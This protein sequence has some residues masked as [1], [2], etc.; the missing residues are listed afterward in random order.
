MR[1]GRPSAF[2]ASNGYKSKASVQFDRR[3][4]MR[5]I[6][7]A[8]VAP[9]K[10]PSFS[11]VRKKLPLQRKTKSARFIDS[12]HFGSSVL[13]EPGYPMQEC[14]LL[15]TLRR[16]GIG[17]AH[18]LDHHIK[19]LMHINPKLDRASAAIKLAAGFLV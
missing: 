16:L 14:L 17:S 6:F 10:T 2:S 12:V 7:C 4:P 11:A 19:I 3:D 9:K 13:L 5:G 18:L 15:Q 1:P 8:E